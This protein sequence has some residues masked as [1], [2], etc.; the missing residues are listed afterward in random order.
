METQ[1]IPRCYYEPKII[2]KQRPLF[3]EQE[4][5]NLLPYEGEE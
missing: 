4:D 1:G 2:T 5:G 3:E